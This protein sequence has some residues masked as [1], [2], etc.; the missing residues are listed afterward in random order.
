MVYVLRRHG[1]FGLFSGS[2]SMQNHPCTLV[3]DIH[4]EIKAT[5]GKSRSLCSRQVEM[6]KIVWS[7][8]S[9]R[10]LH[11][12]QRMKVDAKMPLA[13]PCKLSVPSTVAVWSTRS[14]S[15]CHTV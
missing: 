7:K 6:V 1:Y 11:H 8:E 13:K 15:T 9:M 4:L 12:G 10:P 3:P 14:T 2:C 5:P